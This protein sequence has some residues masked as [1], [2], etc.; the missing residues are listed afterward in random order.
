[1]NHLAT[2][3]S[4]EEHPESFPVNA[5]GESCVLHLPLPDDAQTQ[6]SKSPS[7]GN[8]H[9]V[10]LSPCLAASHLDASTKSRHLV[11]IPG[12]PMENNEVN[13]IR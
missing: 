1:M 10:D 3:A 13:K 12:T 9:T 8:G 2:A 6:G 5:L 4:F 11:P 7:H